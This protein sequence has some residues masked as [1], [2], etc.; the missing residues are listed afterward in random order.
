MFERAQYVHQERVPSTGE[1]L[2]APTVERAES[3]WEGLKRQ[4]AEHYKGDTIP[5]RPPCTGESLSA[6]TEPID[7]LRSGGILKHFAIGNIIK[8]SYRCRGDRPVALTVSDCDKIIHYAEMLKCLAGDQTE[9][10]NE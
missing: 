2:S 10:A 9:A 6:P 3:S 8:Y 1:S 4:G 5:S 7:L